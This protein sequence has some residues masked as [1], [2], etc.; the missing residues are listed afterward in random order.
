MFVIEPMIKVR[1]IRNNPV[2]FSFVISG[3]PIKSSQFIMHKNR[4]LKVPYSEYLVRWNQIPAFSLNHSR[5]S[6]EG[7]SNGRL[8]IL[9]HTNC[10]KT[11]KARLTPNITV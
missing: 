2:C 3:N 10:D 7:R 1:Q 4:G 9:S 8:Y 5:V 11:P 6:D